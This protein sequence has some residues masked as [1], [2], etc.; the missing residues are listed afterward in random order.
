MFGVD[1]DETTFLTAIVHR[2]LFER[3][4]IKLDLLLTS[5]SDDTSGHA[6]LI[7]SNV[8]SFNMT[9]EYGRVTAGRRLKLSSRSSARNTNEDVS[10]LKLCTMAILISFDLTIS[11]RSQLI[12]NLTRSL[13]AITKCGTAE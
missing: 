3:F 2:P 9:V 6:R 11:T 7:N 4:I 5:I 10:L 12:I 8:L 1:R 13:N